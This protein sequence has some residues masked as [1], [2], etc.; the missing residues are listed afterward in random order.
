M[1]VERPF[2]NFLDLILFPR[3]SIFK[4]QKDLEESDSSESEEDTEDE[5]KVTAAPKGK[6]AHC[7]FCQDE[8]LPC[9]CRCLLTK[10][11]CKCIDKVDTKKKEEF[12]SGVFDTTVAKATDSMVGSSKNNTF[13]ANT[14]SEIERKRVSFDVSNIK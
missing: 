12:Q 2:K 6:Q 14:K 1:V 11:K 4:K 7:G 9:D 5:R 13:L 8:A 10:K 3:S